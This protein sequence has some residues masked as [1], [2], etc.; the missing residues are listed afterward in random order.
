MSSGVLSRLKPSAL[1]I[2]LRLDKTRIA[3][4]L[5]RFKSFNVHPSMIPTLTFRLWVI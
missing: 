2:V 4:L 5:N 3:N 1:A